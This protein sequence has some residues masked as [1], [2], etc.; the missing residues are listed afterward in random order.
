MTLSLWLAQVT[1][2]ST[3]IVD[4]IPQ[5]LFDYT[6]LVEDN[7]W[8]HHYSPLFIKLKGWLELLGAVGVITPPQ[9][10]LYPSVNVIA[11]MGVLL[12]LLG[13]MSTLLL[14]GSSGP[15]WTLMV[16]LTVVAAFVSCTHLK[17]QYAWG[18]IN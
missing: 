10:S 3:L 2:A 18:R 6:S 13:M 15:S 9:L 11:A 1:L 8:I 4:G 17:E 12:I 16:T 14:T 5:A 7:T